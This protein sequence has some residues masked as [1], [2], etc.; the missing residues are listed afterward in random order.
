MSAEA[1][2]CGQCYALRRSGQPA[3]QS[4]VLPGGQQFGAQT[5]AAGPAAS[6]VTPVRA[7]P[8]KTLAPATIKTRWRKTP[9]TFG[10]MGRILATGALVVPE[11]LFIAVGILT[12]GFTIAGAVIWGGVIMPWG[13]KDTWRAGT[14]PDPNAPALPQAP[15][16]GIVWSAPAP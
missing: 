9:T 16:S 14:M 6:T 13:L 12:G 11:I 2:W 8:T 3:M 15:S 4:A 5:P 7:V 10:P 1:E